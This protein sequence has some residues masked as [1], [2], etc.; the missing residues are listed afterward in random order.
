LTEGFGGAL[1]N[2][3]EAFKKVIAAMEAGPLDDKFFPNYNL[4][5][6]RGYAWPCWDLKNAPC[7][8]ANPDSLNPGN[9]LREMTVDPVLI[10]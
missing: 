8:S 4:D 2:C 5:G 9:Q 3:I 6:D 10:P 1:A 7:Q